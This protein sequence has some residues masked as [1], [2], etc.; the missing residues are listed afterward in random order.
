MKTSKKTYFRVECPVCGF[1]T[2]GNWKQ[3][4]VG[5]YYGHYEDKHYPKP[6]IKKERK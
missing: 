5:Q 6:I 1:Y 4:Q 2:V 3:M